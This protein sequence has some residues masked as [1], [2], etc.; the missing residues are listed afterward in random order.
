MQEEDGLFAFREV[1]S[2]GSAVYLT[3]F[4]SSDGLMSV[5]TTLKMTYLIH[6]TQEEEDPWQKFVKGVIAR[7]I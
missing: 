6:L 1:Y 7:R 5:G 2:P 3:V 4:R